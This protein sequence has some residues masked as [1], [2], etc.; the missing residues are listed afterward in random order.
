MYAS[1]ADREGNAI[2]GEIAK[3]P[4]M[5]RAGLLRVQVVHD[6]GQ[7]RHRWHALTVRDEANILYKNLLFDELASLQDSPLNFETFFWPYLPSLCFTFDLDRPGGRFV[8]Y[9]GTL[10]SVWYVYQTCCSNL[11]RDA[12]V[13]MPPRTQRSFRFRQSGTVSGHRPF[14]ST[15]GLSFSDWNTPATVIVILCIRGNE[16]L[17][18]SE[19]SRIVK[20]K[21][22]VCHDRDNFLYSIFSLIFSTCAL[23]MEVIIAI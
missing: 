8:E 16:T 12:H 10:L 21:M 9:A 23:S 19:L 17:W 6:V 2:S 18:N 15:G 7:Q 22:C 3:G 11:H 1:T 20:N 13:Q 5:G 14:Y 4:W